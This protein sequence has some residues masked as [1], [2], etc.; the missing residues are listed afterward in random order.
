MPAGEWGAGMDGSFGMDFFMLYFGKAVCM[1]H[2]A[3]SSP[4]DTLWLLS[5]DLLIF[6]SLYF[7]SL[8]SS[9]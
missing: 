4:A 2:A 1:P 3:A 6:R 5:L 8:T 9:C 7:P